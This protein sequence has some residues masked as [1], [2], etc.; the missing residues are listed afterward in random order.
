[1][2]DWSSRAAAHVAGYAARAGFLRFQGVDAK[3][4]V[5]AGSRNNFM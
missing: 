5:K 2:K 1:M 4:W 3:V